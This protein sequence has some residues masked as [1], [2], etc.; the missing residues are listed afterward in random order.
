MSNHKRRARQSMIS[1]ASTGH[2]LTVAEM[3][4]AIEQFPDDAEIIFG[5]CP[6]DEPLKF[7]RFKKRG[8]KTLGI[9]FG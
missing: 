7:Y 8:E 2:V 9:E 3:L 5:T 4:D 1:G 6:H